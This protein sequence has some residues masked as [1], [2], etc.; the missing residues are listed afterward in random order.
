LEHPFQDFEIVIAHDPANTEAKR[1]LLM[2]QRESDE[3]ET[4]SSTSSDDDEC[5]PYHGEKWVEASDS[6]S[7]DYLHTLL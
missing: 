1:E 6:D 7:S 3:G 4:L 2:A 5:P